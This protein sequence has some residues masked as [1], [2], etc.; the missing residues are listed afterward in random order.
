[1]TRDVSNEIF[2]EAGLTVCSLRSRLNKL[3]I[4]KGCSAKGLALLRREVEYGVG[5]R[6][7][8]QSNKSIAY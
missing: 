5:T 7:Q 4:M 1:M 3:T 2:G 8:G 6:G